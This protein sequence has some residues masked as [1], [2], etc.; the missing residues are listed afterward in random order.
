MLRLLAWAVVLTIISASSTVMARL[1]GSTR[2]P[3][4]SAIF[5]HPDGSPCERPCLF[6][7]S[8]GKTDARQARLALSSHPITRDAHWTNNRQLSMVSLPSYVTF[9]E[10][11]DGVV[12]EISITSTPVFRI[13]SKPL[14]GSLLDSISAGDLVLTYGVPDAIVFSSDYLNI[15]YSHNG[16]FGY[17]LSPTSFSDHVQ[18]ETSLTG[19]ILYTPGDCPANSGIK[20]GGTRKG[21]TTMWR[22]MP[23]SS[24]EVTARNSGVPAM[25]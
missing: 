16:L 5:A 18:L 2:P 15:V 11:P 17:F 25:P 3:P 1:I 9:S 8:P 10:T 20:R 13:G 22:Y 14:P 23:D 7:I 19:L 12:K 24:V 6:G 4:I 21:L